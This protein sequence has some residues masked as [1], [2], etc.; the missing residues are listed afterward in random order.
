MDT[1]YDFLNVSV[2]D[3]IGRIF[4]NRPPVNVL[5]IQMM[6]DLNDALDK[7]S[8]DKELKLLE[9][10]AE[11]KA[12]CA[13]VEVADH[14]PDVVEDMIA[15][16]DGIFE[17][18]ARLEIPSLAVVNGA[19]VG[20]GCELVAGCDMVIAS[21]RSKFGQPEIKLG[22]FP[23]FAAYALPRLV[24]RNRA[25]EICL[26]GDSIDADR[27]AAIGLINWAVE[28][29]ELDDKVKQLENSIRENSALIIRI[30]KK[31][32]D[33]NLGLPFSDAVSNLDDLFLNELLKTDD[34]LEGMNAF[35]E[36][37]KPVWKNR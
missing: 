16:F 29:E 8:T 4:L 2:D 24:G 26:F 18:L 20:G 19:A 5:N 7:L 1:T 13:G 33:A 31:S 11:G 12:F 30:A 28:E 14:A 15:Q 10:L 3:G 25:I 9:I 36:K 17:R 37:R 35:L 32:I 6:S 34:T 21:K 22:F 23:P 27:A